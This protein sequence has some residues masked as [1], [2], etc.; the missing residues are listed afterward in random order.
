V[1]INPYNPP[2]SASS[3]NESGCP[4]V[5]FGWNVCFWL[6]V[7]GI[8]IDIGIVASR[9]MTTGQSGLPTSMP[10][11]LLIALAQ[12]LMVFSIRWIL[13]RLI[14][15]R[16]PPGDLQG[17]V[18]LV[19]VIVIFTMIKLIEYQGFRLWSA[20]GDLGKFF[21]FLPISLV[22]MFFMFPRRLARFS[23]AARIGKLEEWTPKEKR[24]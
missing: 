4:D 23:Q 19:G 5:P 16:R 7:V 9:F 21:V 8:A 15:R 22:L 3:S 13:F 11:L 17:I 20:S 1:T 6:L 10:A 2:Q 18:P 14:L 12:S 24:P